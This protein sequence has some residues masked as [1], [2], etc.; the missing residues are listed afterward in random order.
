MQII[1]IQ[2]LSYS[3]AKIEKEYKIFLFKLFTILLF[4]LSKLQLQNRFCI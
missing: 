3:F 4:K 1:S 2:I